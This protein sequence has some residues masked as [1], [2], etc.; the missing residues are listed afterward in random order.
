[1][2]ARWQNTPRREG[3]AAEPSTDAEAEVVEVD[4]LGDSTARRR[5]D[6]GRAQDA[7]A[8]AGKAAGGGEWRKC[9]D[10]YLEAYK[11][12]T[13][14]WPLRYNVW[15]GFTSVLRE[16]RF[17]PTSEDQGELELVGD[18]TD[19]PTLHRVLAHFSHAFIHH[20]S[21]RYDLTLELYERALSLAVAMP[22]RERSE[23]VQL[24]GGRGYE[25]RNVGKLVDELSVFL[26]D[27]IRRTKTEIRDEEA[28]EGGHSGGAQGGESSA[29]ATGDASGL[30]Y[31]EAVVR[32]KSAVEFI[33]TYHEIA[34]RKRGEIDDEIRSALGD[35]AELLLTDG[36]AGADGAV[37]L[38][39]AAA[40][41][42]PSSAVPYRLRLRAKAAAHRGYEISEYNGS[43][44]LPQP[45]PRKCEVHSCVLLA[46]DHDCLRA[47]PRPAGREG[48]ADAGLAGSEGRL[49]SGES[50]VVAS[51][52]ACRSRPR[53]HLQ[54]IGSQYE[55]RIAVRE[56]DVAADEEAAG[57]AAAA[58]AGGDGA[59][60]PPREGARRAHAHVPGRSST[61]PVRF[62]SEEFYRDHVMGFRPL[63]LRG[64]SR[65]S[66][67]EPWDDE[68]LKKRC[69]LADGSAWHAIV[70]KNNRVI[71]NDRHPLMDGWTFC[72][73]IYRYQLPEYNNLLYVITPL[74]QEGNLL[75]P[76]LT[77]PHALGCTQL[78]SSFYEA[79]LWMSGGNTTSSLHFDT[80]DNLLM[81]VDGRK[82]TLFWN[83]TSEVRR[84]ST[85]PAT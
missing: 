18:S 82:T 5:G 76:E 41:A 23:D 84:V 45:S 69:A 62:S 71:R 56:V 7:L 37:S 85:A 43:I 11:V 3:A 39:A 2:S 60:A 77:L 25:Y 28:A 8:A 49:D 59:A 34:L 21:G 33:L 27:N 14:N 48:A 19:A 26:R 36:A 63:L 24:P 31:D 15:S 66:I 51:S 30:R 10:Y 17:A 44:P 52:P 75:R 79:R 9:A 74:S 29:L 70:E 78:Y 47:L 40:V 35:G 73:Y 20:T 57:A 50:A 55:P 22:P 58:A 81:Q 12:C 64:G 46:E 53:G 61:R 80:H 32:T 67:R 65:A 83:P 38:A 6:D 16:G 68:F 72:D 13:P 54:H 1:M 42:G 4:P